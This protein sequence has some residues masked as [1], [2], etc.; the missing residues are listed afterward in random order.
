MTAPPAHPRSPS[1]LD[2][3]PQPPVHRRRWFRRGL[4]LATVVALVVAGWMFVP[5][6]WRVMQFIRW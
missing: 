5:T 1:E 6:Y 3:A 2:Y 4:V